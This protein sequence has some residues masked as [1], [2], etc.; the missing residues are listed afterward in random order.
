MATWKFGSISKAEAEKLLEKDGGYP[1]GRFLVRDRGSGGKPGDLV[2]SLNFKNRPTHH[3]IST[4]A[5]T[6][7][8]TINN[9]QF[10]SPKSIEEAVEL[11]S[12]TPL[13]TGWPVQLTEGVV[14]P[15]VQASTPAPAI[16]P[17]PTPQPAAV[18][19]QPANTSAAYGQMSNLHPVMTKPEAAALL[20]TGD[21][22]DGK[23][24]LR[25]RAAGNDKEFVLSVIYKGKP[26]H[27][28]LAQ[29]PDDSFTVNSNKLPCS[30]LDDVV[31]HLR[32]ARSFWPVPLKEQVKPGQAAKSQ[33][34]NTAAEQQRQAEQQ[35]LLEEK[36]K[37]E[38]EAALQAQRQR[39][40]EERIRREAEAAKAAEQQ[41]RQEEE[42]E[43]ER[44]RQAQE[45]RER[46]AQ[47]QRARE[48]EEAR[49][50]RQQ[51]EEEQRRQELLQQ[52]QQ[53]RQQLQQQQQ[54]DN[55]YGVQTDPSD[56]YLRTRANSQKLAH[57]HDEVS[58]LSDS[59]MSEIEVER[60]KR[61]ELSRQQ[62]WENG[63][64]FDVHVTRPNP[65]V[66]FGFGVAKMWRIDGSLKVISWVD[67]DGPAA[68]KLE[69]EDVI[70]ALNGES[71]DELALEQLKDEIRALGNDFRARIFRPH[72]KRS[73]A[74]SQLP[75]SVARGATP[76]KKEK[77]K[78]KK[79]KPNRVPPKNGDCCGAIW[80]HHQA[81]MQKYMK[82]EEDTLKMI[83]QVTK[84]LGGT[85]RLQ[86]VMSSRTRNAPV[87]DTSV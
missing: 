35:R 11:L 10:G 4:K 20:A 79:V 5:D 44:E 67:P 40:E 24:L 52:Q 7:V 77:G 9:K 66:P 28:L 8:L 1:S 23:F 60:Q 49:A 29:T 50:R 21:K 14:N 85:E 36:Q 82:E 64:Q 42:E 75:Q 83:M 81:N 80:C 56:L 57:P 61:I 43:A 86:F 17:T 76:K 15:E 38:R 45:Q 69:A 87:D 59:H 58:V 32:V 6:G 65:G 18:A 37:K 3:L 2:L 26:T 31:E 27:H 55:P 41:R 72:N 71:A 30:N 74:Q 53:Q 70:M 25:P 46:E 16:S 19:P 33:P 84:R 12:K 78:K 34:D 68:G 13:P 62:R 39:E 48:E 51:Q 54:Q 22:H 47:E 73:D 63:E